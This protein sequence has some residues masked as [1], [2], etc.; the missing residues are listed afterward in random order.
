MKPE[1]GR[2]EIKLLVD[3]VHQIVDLEKLEDE[4]VLRIT[5]YRCMELYYKKNGEKGFETV[6]AMW[7]DISKNKSEPE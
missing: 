1:E 2:K 6:L 4:E 7:D 5:L 3:A